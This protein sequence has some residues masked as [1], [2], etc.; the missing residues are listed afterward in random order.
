MGQGRLLAQAGAVAH[1][2]PGDVH[3]RHGFG[4][5]AP[6]RQALHQL[7]HRRP[8]QGDL[9]VEVG[10]AL[11]GVLQAQLRGQ[12][13]EEV[14]EV[15]RDQDGAG[16]GL[17]D[18]RRKVH[19]VLGILG[20]VVELIV[21]HEGG[22]HHGDVDVLALAGPFTED[23]GGQQ[24]DQA[25]QGGVGVGHRQGQ[26]AARDAVA[27]GLAGDQ[28]HLGV[29][30]GGVGRPARLR[31]AGAEAGDGQ[32]DQARIGLRQDVI[33]QPQ[34]AH[35]VGPVVLD[36]DVGLA[37]QVQHQLPGAGCAQ[38]DA[39]V[40]LAGV[41]LVEKAG[42]ATLHPPPI[43]GDVALRRLDLDH[44]GAQVREQAPGEGTGQDAGEI[45]HP[46]P[47]QRIVG[48]CVGHVP[49]EGFER[50]VC[51]DRAMPSARAAAVDG[52]PGE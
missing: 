41:L 45:Q 49:P 11:A 13:A 38:V 23:H 2:A 31:P 25:V 26:V 37:D 35:D 19:G 21:R 1:L 33:S 5:L 17:P 40:A 10:D 16:A 7:A 28:P 12:L 47:G 36:Q 39:D 6:V 50:P 24:A 15:R 18:V 46:Q 20:L 32:H 42:Y 22:V 27:P 34:P 48:K 9:A 43:T 44:V 52:P 8:A 14:A 29:H 3:G 30:D 51:Y 4:H